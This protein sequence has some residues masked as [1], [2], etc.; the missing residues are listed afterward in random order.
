[1]EISKMPR[2]NNK[3]NPNPNYVPP[4]S[5]KKEIYTE[6]VGIPV[7]GVWRYRCGNIDCCKLIPFCCEQYEFKYCPYCGLKVRK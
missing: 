6:W 7:D 2:N 1:M 5:V 4:A 3:Q